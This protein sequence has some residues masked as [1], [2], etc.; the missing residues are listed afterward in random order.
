MKDQERLRIDIA[1]IVF[2]IVSPQ[3]KPV[4][5]QKPY[6]NFLSVAQPRIFIR[7]SYNGLP[8]TVFRDSD[9]IFDS[10]GGWRLY[11]SEGQDA[12]VLGASVFGSLPYRI[13]FFSKDVGQVRVYSE[14]KRL[15]GGLFPDPLEYPLSEV[16]MICLLAQ[17]RGLM[18]HACGVKD[19]D[20][21]LLFAGISRA[22]KSTMANLWKGKKDITVL[23]DDRIIIR[24][25]DG[26]FWIYGT[27]WHGDAKVCSP[28][29][30]PLEKIFFLKHAKNNTIK[31]ID[32]LEAA[33]RLIV[34]SFP[35]FWDK[36]G[37]EFTL[38]FCAKLA[39]EI[40]CYELG[41]VPDKSVLDFVKNV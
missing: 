18:V 23:S 5:Q 36:K 24:K 20:G 8:Q 28:E 30:A 9:L 10:G 15:P 13:A 4:I 27:P 11:R 26:Q 40:P 2:S 39:E 41:F 21:G 31:K 34:C 6:R 33:S 19:N 14:A 16:L 3:D 38:K 35:T 25:M 22:G 32:L 1:G 37:M 7:A 29:R 12:I 17:G